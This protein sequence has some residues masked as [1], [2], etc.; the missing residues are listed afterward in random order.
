MLL[1]FSLSVVGTVQGY[2]KKEGTTPG[3]WKRRWFVLKPATLQY[4]KRPDSTK[5]QG[6]IPIASILSIQQDAAAYDRMFC[7]Q[8]VR[9]ELRQPL[10]AAATAACLPAACL[11]ARR[12][13]ADYHSSSYI[14]HL[15]WRQLGDLTCVEHW[16]PL[17][18]A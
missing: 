3:S 16:H 15:R 11:P 10:C 2:M 18:A 8:L 13:D 14:S 7:F 5:V 4:L 9:P 17:P 1:A 6:S 12:S